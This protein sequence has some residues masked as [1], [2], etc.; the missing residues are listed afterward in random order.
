MTAEP[1]RS[2]GFA[3]YMKANAA[4]VRGRVSLADRYPGDGW[5]LPARGHGISAHKIPA[6]AGMTG[7]A[8]NTGVAG[9]GL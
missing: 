3:A 9:G 7:V 6:V 4:R 8:G 1:A 5:G 2:V